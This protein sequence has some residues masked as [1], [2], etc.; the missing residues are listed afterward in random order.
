[1]KRIKKSSRFSLLAVFLILSLLLTSSFVF[2]GDNSGNQTGVSFKIDTGGNVEYA[3]SLTV[4]KVVEGNEPAGIDSYKMHLTGPDCDESF[5]L[6]DGDDLEFK[7]LNG[8]YIVEET[9]VFDGSDDQ[10][11]PG[12]LTTTYEV[13]GVAGNSATVTPGVIA[14]TCDIT[15]TGS[16]YKI[17]VNDYVYRVETGYLDQWGDPYEYPQWELYYKG[18]ANPIYSDTLTYSQLDE[19]WNNGNTTIRVTAEQLSNEG[20]TLKT[21]DYYFIV[22]QV[23]DHPPQGASCQSNDITV[24]SVGSSAT[25]TV[26][27]TFT[28]VET[29]SLKVIKEIAEGSAE[30]PTN[31]DAFQF[32]LKQKVGDGWVLYPDE[33]SNPYSIAYP[34]PGYYE[35]AELPVGTYK[36]E[37]ITTGLTGLVSGYPIYSPDD[38]IT[39]AKDEA[40][41]ITITNKFETGNAYLQIEKYRD[42]E[43][44]TVAFP[45]NEFKYYLY[46]QDAADPD[47]WN[48][49]DEDYIN[50]TGPVFN[51]PLEVTPGVKYRVFEDI[52]EL[53]NNWFNV[54]GASSPKDVYSDGYG[55]GVEFTVPEPS[56]NNPNVLV[57]VEITNID[58]GWLIVS[59]AC[60]GTGI[61]E[62]GVYQFYLYA[63]DYLTQAYVLYSQTPYE[64]NSANNYQ[65]TIPVQFETCYKVIEIT[66]PGSPAYDTWKSVYYSGGD[67][68]DYNEAQNIMSHGDLQEITITNIFEENC[69]N[70]VKITKYLTESSSS[71]TQNSFEVELLKLEDGNWETYTGNGVDT[72]PFNI[73]IGETV[74][75]TNLD[76]GE[77]KVVE[78]DDSYLKYIYVNNVKTNEFAID[79]TE[80]IHGNSADNDGIQRIEVEIYN[81]FE[82]DTPGDDPELII[83][84]KIG[85]GNSTQNDYTVEIQKWNDNS[86]EWETQVTY[87]DLS[88]SNPI[89]IEL[90]DLIIKYGEGEYRVVETDTD[91]ISKWKSFSYTVDG[92]ATG[93]DYAPFDVDEDSEDD[94]TV[95]VTNNFKTSHGGGD[96]SWPILT[97]EKIVKGDTTE[98]SFTVELL[99]KDGDD[100]DVADTFTIEDGE[101]LTIDMEDYGAGTYM[102]VEDTDEIDDKNFESVSYK[103]TGDTTDD[104]FDVVK[105]GRSS[106][107]VVTNN[108]EEEEEVI[109]KGAEPAEP[110]I[111]P[112]PAPELPKTGAAPIAA[113]LGLLLAASGLALR[114]NRK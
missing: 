60:T 93:V 101:T 81:E 114:R 88:V 102:V 71:A 110:V 16:S 79:T 95:V 32:N 113:G 38:E 62:N 58:P 92:D 2:A 105:N 61:P 10:P 55:W 7:N 90:S 97:I 56:D 11:L 33:N 53:W 68:I 84:K 48:L 69:G 85:S 52:P 108:F 87:T 80:G 47:Q 91:S 42:P 49:I 54:D 4:K 18:D 5:Y 29:A 75:L 86:S 3:G 89:S 35:F 45:Q 39:L 13:D 70:E 43:D 104:E 67:G 112:E 83:K 17:S 24:D 73:Q 111:I 63:W 27:N 37:E 28:K 12:N 26:T 14:L 107:V 82:K 41:E 64:L 106:K 22:N 98:D 66:P 103:V 51:T 40:G 100:W 25:L 76:L 23:S 44:T 96:D 65:I 78:N 74:T 20:F 31:T 109:I 59:K 57:T 8:T 19:L 94:I 21:G 15:N 9:Y 30:L 77:Y 99:E 1:M 36:V 34:T 6:V 72:N 50:S 46:E